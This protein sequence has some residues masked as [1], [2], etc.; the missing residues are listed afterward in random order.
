MEASFHSKPCE[1]PGLSDPGSNSCGIS[2]DSGY[3]ESGSIVRNASSISTSGF[4]LRSSDSNPVQRTSAAS[5]FLFTS[6]L[7]L[8]EFTYSYRLVKGVR[9][10]RGPKTQSLFVFAQYEQGFVPEHCR[11]GISI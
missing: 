3:S 5:K 7:E 11:V 8:T 6:A 10:G 1:E 2:T 9:D 4:N